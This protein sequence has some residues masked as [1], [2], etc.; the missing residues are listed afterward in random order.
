MVLF[1]CTYFVIAIISDISGI[2]R[3]QDKLDDSSFEPADL[4]RQRALA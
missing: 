2:D 3:R 1:I 4:T